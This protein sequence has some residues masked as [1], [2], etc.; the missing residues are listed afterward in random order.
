MKNFHRYFYFSK[1]SDNVETPL[2][3]R[4]KM[5]SYKN[6]YYIFFSLALLCLLPAFCLSQTFHDNQGNPILYYKSSENV[7]FDYAGNSKFYLKRD[8]LGDVNIYNFNG[9]HLGWYINGTLRDHQGRI[10]ASETNKLLNVTYKMPPIKPVERIIP[11][12]G[13]EELA[14][15]KPLWNDQFSSNYILTYNGNPSFNQQQNA[16]YNTPND[17]TALQQRQPYSLPVD[18]IVSTVEALNQQAYQQKI[19]HQQLI[20]QGLIYYNGNYITQERYNQIIDYEKYKARGFNQTLNLLK[21]KGFKA[22]YSNCWIIVQ[23]ADEKNKEL[24]PAILNINRDKD[25]V[26]VIWQNGTEKFQ[27]NNKIRYRAQLCQLK[28]K[29]NAVS[30]ILFGG[31]IEVTTGQIWIFI[32]ENEVYFYSKRNAKEHFKALY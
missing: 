26:K 21:S 22:K 30:A 24:V 23:I 9:K 25:V 28:N 29:S 2:N 4:F 7:F 8:N 32:E 5:T 17:Y 16:P 1:V 11:I 12:K 18:D 20:A 31:N 3:M 27:K 15:I 19:R 13:V 6:K 10:M 14:P